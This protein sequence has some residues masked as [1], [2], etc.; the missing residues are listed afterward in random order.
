MSIKD[1]VN[2]LKKGAD[3]NLS[4]EETLM[5]NMVALMKYFHWTLEDV[6]KLNKSQFEVLSSLVSKYEERLKEAQEKAW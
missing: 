1:K 2:R 5:L 4:K 6:L 3:K